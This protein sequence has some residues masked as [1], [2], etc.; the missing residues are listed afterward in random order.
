MFQQHQGESLSEARTRFKD[1]LSKAP[2]HRIDWWL[3]IQIFYDHCNSATKRTIDQAGGGKLSD[4]NAN[5][6]WTILDDL[7]LYDNKNW[8]DPKD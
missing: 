6:F 1:L 8:I 3:Q 5:E 4:K 7:A 2:H